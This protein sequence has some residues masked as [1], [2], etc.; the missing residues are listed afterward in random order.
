MHTV[1][2]RCADIKN[3][4]ENNIAS[5]PLFLTKLV[6]EGN[7]PADKAK[8]YCKKYMVFKEKLDKMNIKSGILVQRSMGH[9][10][11]N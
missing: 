9:C 8:M 5:T 4:H 3:Q 11:I 1:N 2:L 10:A 6:P 7:P